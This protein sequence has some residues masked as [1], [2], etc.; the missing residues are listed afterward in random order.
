VLSDCLYDVVRPRSGGVLRPRTL[1][2]NGGRAGDAQCGGHV[3]KNV[4]RHVIEAIDN[5]GIY[6][7]WHG[8]V[9]CQCI[10]CLL[11][12]FSAISPIPS[13]IIL[14]QFTDNSISDYAVIGGFP[15]VYY[16]DFPAAVP[17]TK[18]DTAN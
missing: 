13:S 17:F 3:A 16:R 11:L 6:P 8:P 7:Y 18:T 2:M 1:L 12:S 15:L 4:I 10:D 9:R 5:F 14:Q